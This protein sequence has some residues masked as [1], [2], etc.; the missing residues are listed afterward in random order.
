MNKENQMKYVEYLARFAAYKA[1]ITRIHL[2]IGNILPMPDG[3][4]VHVHVLYLEYPFSHSEHFADLY[5]TAHW[6]LPRQ[7]FVL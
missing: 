7:A 6:L 5:P 2:R 1:P 4:L 3:H